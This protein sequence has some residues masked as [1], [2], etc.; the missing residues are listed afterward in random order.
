[1][2]APATKSCVVSYVGLCCAN[3]RLSGR[4]KGII[5]PSRIQT[6][7]LSWATYA[8][9][10]RVISNNQLIGSTIFHEIPKFLFVQS[11]VKSE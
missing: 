9:L 2:T 1:M 3:D 10:M 8:L 7:T 11:Y 4:G 5:R 6:R